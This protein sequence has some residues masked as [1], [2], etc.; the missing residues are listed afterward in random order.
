MALIRHG[1]VRRAY[2]GI[3]GQTIPLDRRI[4]RHFGLAQDSGVRIDSLETGSPAAGAGLRVGDVIIALGDA[5]IPSIDA[6]QQALDA[7]AIGRSVEVSVLRR[8][9]R[10]TIAVVPTESIRAPIRS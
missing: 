5:G 4:V 7:E 2:L 3:G 6:L 1:R 8:H 9:A 10:A